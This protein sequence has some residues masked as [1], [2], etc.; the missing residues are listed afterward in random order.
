MAVLD[1]RKG[2]AVYVS[3]HITISYTF[4]RC[5]L[6]IHNRYVDH[7]WQYIRNST[8]GGHCYKPRQVPLC[9]SLV[10][11]YALHHFSACEEDKRAK[12]TQ[13][14]IG[15]PHRLNITCT[16]TLTLYEL[17]YSECLVH[18]GD[19]SLGSLASLGNLI[20]TGLFCMKNGKIHSTGTVLFLCKLFVGCR[21]ITAL[22]N[23][24]SGGQRSRAE[25]YST[26]R[27]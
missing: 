13:G 3:V 17:H 24:H 8:Q 12:W 21:G 16:Y 26:G 10:R 20:A 7:M 18:C 6:Q 9:H 11:R 25:L 5:V 22:T 27:R 1:V 2:S 4:N 23:D 19:V 15:A 14:W